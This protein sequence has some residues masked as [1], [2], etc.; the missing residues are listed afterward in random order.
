LLPFA[1]FLPSKLRELAI[2]WVAS[3]PEDDL[4]CPCVGCRLRDAGVAEGE[5]VEAEE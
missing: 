2:A 1:D 5:G 3:S 4:L